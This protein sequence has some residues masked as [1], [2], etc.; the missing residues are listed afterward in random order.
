MNVEVHKPRSMTDVTPIREEV[1][2]VVR[3]WREAATHVVLVVIALVGLPLTVGVLTGSFWEFPWPVSS[4]AA[5]VYGATLVALCLPRRLYRWRAAILL[6]ALYAL[7]VEQLALTGLVGAGRITVLVFPL[8]ALILLGARAGWIAA[9]MTAILLAALTLL[10]ANGRLTSWQV[11]QENSLDLGYWVLQGLLL[12][13]A[14]I[15]LM[16]LFAR[17]LALQTRTLLA[18]RQARRE[19]E[20]ESATRRHL[21]GEL[22]RVSEDERRRLGAELHDGLCQHLTA[23]LLHCTAVENQLA[24]QNMPEAG[25][26]SRLRSM[27][28]ESIGTAY[29][30][31]K[32]LCPVDL[33]PDALS[34]AL[35]RL[36]RQTHK[37]TGVICEFR[38][39]GPVAIRDPRQTIHLYRI[40]QEAVT[41]AVKHAR[42]RR[43]RLELLGLADATTLRVQDDGIGSHSAAHP[44][45]GGMGVRLMGHRAEVLG[46]TLTIEHPPAGGTL[47]TCRVP[48]SSVPEKA[49]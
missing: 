14:L 45:F 3:A 47:V 9:S 10:A 5:S 13:L 19:L 49:A 4:V 17:F 32:G 34:S 23:A 40:A 26:T 16:I 38:G 22:L 35:Q 1:D 15:P 44:T 28:E 18:E 21:E 39:E 30:V 8:L 31:A 43:L 2:A 37:T 42:C 27:I 33:D 29:D 6:S 41:N 25:P 11:I 24:S 12:L 48:A 7:A 46:G 20:Y 36:A